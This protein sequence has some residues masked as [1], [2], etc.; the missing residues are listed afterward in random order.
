MT[1]RHASPAAPSTLDSLRLA[2]FCLDDAGVAWVR[3]W[4]DRLSTGQK[5][6]QLFNLN[7]KADDPASVAAMAELGVGGVTRLGGQDLA[8]HWHA[9]RTLAER[10]EIP[11][12]ISGDI[13]GGAIALP[14]GSQLPNQLGLAATGSTALAEEAV[15]VLAREA[16]SLGFNWSFT[17]VVDINAAFRS[18]IVATRSYGSNLDTILAQAGRQE[19]GGFAQ[20]PVRAL[21]LGARDGAA[22]Y[23]LSAFWRRGAAA[24][25]QGSLRELATE[26]G[27]F[28]A[29]EAR[30]RG[31]AYWL[32]LAGEL[33]RIV[34]DGGFGA[35]HVGGSD[36]GPNAPCTLTP[37]PELESAYVRLHEA[38]ER[39]R[40][41][42]DSI[43]HEAAVRR[44]LLPAR[45][46]PRRSG[47]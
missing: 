18:A 4:L 43:E 12:L 42:T 36:P 29:N 13:E 26:I 21:R 41:K 46:R 2:P 3:G 5:L 40:A 44:K 32:D 37:S 11:L 45:R 20:V 27:C 10:S 39:A 9:T 19:P 16:R 24:Q 30:K 1:D 7:A 33:A 22:V 35:L 23:G 8:S 17:P 15:A 28:S 47:L 25:W 31:R 34:Q 14:F 38:R 6:R